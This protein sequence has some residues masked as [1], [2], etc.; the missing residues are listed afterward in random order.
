MKELHGV[1]GDSWLSVVLFDGTIQ[2]PS[3]ATDWDVN[4][5]GVPQF[6][7]SRTGC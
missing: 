7:E 3:G 2:I 1:R 6:F 5:R 4:S